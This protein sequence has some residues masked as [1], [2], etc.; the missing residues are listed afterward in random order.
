MYNYICAELPD[1]TEE[2]YDYA[3][4][5]DYDFDEEDRCLDHDILV[6]ECQGRDCIRQPIG[7]ETCMQCVVGCNGQ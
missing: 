6:F 7:N 1:Y 4:D 2:D 5:Y 3:I